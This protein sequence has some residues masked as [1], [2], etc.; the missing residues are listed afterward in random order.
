[1]SKVRVLIPAY[2][3]A[4]FLV[5]C[6]SSILHHQSFTDLEL[7]VVDDQSSDATLEVLKAFA[8]SDRRVT[9]TVSNAHVGGPTEAIRYAMK[10]CKCEYFTWLGSDDTYAPTYLEVMLASLEEN[11]DVDY[12]F[13]DFQTI[14]EN[15][16]PLQKEFG[17]YFPCDESL[18][19]KSVIH[20]GHNPIPMNGV[21]RMSFLHDL[22]D[23]WINY[24]GN[25]WS[26]DVI[27][28]L[29]HFQQGLCAKHIDQPLINYRVHR[30]QGSKDLESKA[31][32]ELL[33]Y[34]FIFE[35]YNKSKLI[36]IL[37]CTNPLREV[38]LDTLNRMLY[39]YTAKTLFNPTQAQTVTQ[40]ILEKIK[41]FSCEH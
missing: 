24:K 33:V 29:N 41:G 32:N 7:F 11:K 38:H 13:C 31:K 35:E 23:P 39:R 21:W 3:R 30:R 22:D 2:E 34:D 1:M 6:L 28:G 20:N 5:K 18:F 36:E 4:Y 40:L 12:V 19:L 26:C 27:N 37:G 10:T 16:M 14:D 9:L 17:T 8:E 25:V 15:S